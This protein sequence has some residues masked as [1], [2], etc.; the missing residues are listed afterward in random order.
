MR[1]LVALTM[2]CGALA[3]GASSLLAQPASIPAGARVRVAFPRGS[4]AD[5]SLSRLEGAL[6][7]ADDT[8]LTV[9]RRGT[10]NARYL[11]RLGPAVRLDRY[12][13]RGGTQIKRGAL[14]GFAAGAVIGLGIGAAVGGESE[15]ECPA[16]FA[17]GSGAMLG[18]GGAL[19]GTGIGAATPRGRWRTLPLPVQLEPSPVR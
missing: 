2:L 12:E 3:V 1:N 13:G 18:L 17:I 15:C 16:A 4:T 7:A 9:L 10:K 14:L 19:I 11:V 6:I 5:V 8:S